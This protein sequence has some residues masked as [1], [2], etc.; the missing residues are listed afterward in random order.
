MHRLAKQCC[1]PMTQGFH[2]SEDGRADAHPPPDAAISCVIGYPDRVSGRTKI[3][4]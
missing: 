2:V 3:T 1:Q 4:I